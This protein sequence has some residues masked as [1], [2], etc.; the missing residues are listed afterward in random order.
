MAQAMG[1]L[2][3]CAKSGSLIS[4]FR[5]IVLKERFKVHVFFGSVPT[6]LNSW[7]THANNVGTCSI[8]GSN[9]ATTSCE[10]CKTDARKGL[11]VTG[12]VP[13]TSTMR[14]AILEGNLRGLKT[15]DVEPY[16]TKMLH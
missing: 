12:A 14:E 15:E 2:S 1:L 6:D 5:S 13:L 7:L 4:A 8:L 3:A 9:P 11:I 16:L 10:K